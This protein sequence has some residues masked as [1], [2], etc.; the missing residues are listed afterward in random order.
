MHWS[1]PDWYNGGLRISDWRH[2]ASKYSFPNM[3]FPGWRKLSGGIAA[4][5]GA[6]MFSDSWRSCLV[7]QR[8]TERL[9]YGDIGESL[10]LGPNYVAT[11]M[12]SALIAGQGIRSE[13]T[14]VVIGAIVI[15]PL[16]GPTM[17]LAMAATSGDGKL[18]GPR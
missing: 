8:Y 14:A 12:L 16:L 6:K 11:V 18:G 2:D 15:A 1:M 17:G 13:Q 4:G 9:L 10:R 3:S 7:Q 5:S